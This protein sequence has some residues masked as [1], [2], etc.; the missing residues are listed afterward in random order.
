MKPRLPAWDIEQ[1]SK[2]NLQP[3]I[4]H[5]AQYENA[6]RARETPSIKGNARQITSLKRLL[7]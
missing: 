2:K 4:N 7:S 1:Y 5:P 6:K 3:Q